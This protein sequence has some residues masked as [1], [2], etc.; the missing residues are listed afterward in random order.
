MCHTKGFQN[1]FF[2][3]NVGNIIIIN[4]MIL[5]LFPFN[6]RYMYNFWFLVKLSRN[7]LSHHTHRPIAGESNLSGCLLLHLRLALYN[8]AV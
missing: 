5:G 1:D 7:A 4:T 2:C 3:F 6:G 8:T